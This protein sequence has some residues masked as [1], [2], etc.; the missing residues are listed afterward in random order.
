MRNYTLVAKSCLAEEKFSHNFNDLNGNARHASQGEPALREEKTA[1]EG[2][3]AV[4]EAKP[5]ESLAPDQAGATAGGKKSRFTW[6]SRR[7]V[8]QA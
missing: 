3:G 4:P 7:R 6:L 1:M 5:H 8:R 2:G